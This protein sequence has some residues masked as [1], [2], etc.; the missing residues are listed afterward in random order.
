LIF[1]PSVVWSSAFRRSVGII[2]SDRLKPE[3]QT[4]SLRH[5]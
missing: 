3:P 4:F 2:E 5:Q 1:I